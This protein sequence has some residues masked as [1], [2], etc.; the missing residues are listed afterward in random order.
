MNYHFLYWFSNSTYIYYFKITR[1]FLYSLY[2]KT[3]IAPPFSWKINF[4]TH[5]LQTT[6]TMFPSFHTT[7]VLDK[8][9]VSSFY[10]NSIHQ[11]MAF[12]PLELPSSLICIKTI[13]CIFQ[14]KSNS[15]RKPYQYWTV[16]IRK[17]THCLKIFISLL[18]N[19]IVLI[20]HKIV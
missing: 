5:M 3:L 20:P 6:S 7:H 15:K 12:L 11:F 18:S 13:F 8:L 14:F 16:G 19:H 10:G 9:P 4:R 17:T 2:Q 1:V